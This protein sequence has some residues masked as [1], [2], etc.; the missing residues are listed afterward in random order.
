[1]KKAWIAAGLTLAVVGAG[2][3]GVVLNR[4][5]Q[6]AVTAVS[7]GG[8]ERTAAVRV[9][10]VAPQT[11]E[12]RAGQ[13]GVIETLLVERGNAVSVGD[14]LA[15]FSGDSLEAQLKEVEQELSALNVRAEEAAREQ[16]A[17]QA[18]QKEY[19]AVLS[20][21]VSAAE[22][23]QELA[24]SD[25][26]E[27]ETLNQAIEA[28]NAARA[29]A[30][31]AGEVAPYDDT[32]ERS[33]LNAQIEEL[34]ARLNDRT[35]YS[36]EAGKVVSVGFEEGQTVLEGEVLATVE[37]ESAGELRLTGTGLRLGQTLRATVNG[38]TWELSVNRMEGGVGYAKTPAGFPQ[39]GDIEGVVVQEEAKEVCLLPIECVAEDDGGEYAMIL[40]GGVL[41]RRAVT[42]GMDDGTTVAVTS[43][44]GVGEQAAYFPERYADGQRAESKQ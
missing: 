16:E 29:S 32:E 14:S 17:A 11:A 12:I 41:R 19:E 25:T 35:V 20:E 40:E 8:L 26:A 37:T 24:L 31:F 34:K 5:E 21:A 33:R 13:S 22:S 1:M 2:A 39:S 15:V 38:K 36:T 3:L 23:A 9:E 42:T 43:G 18:A 30:V 7:R 28:A 10:R 27:Y 4:P 44:V 6:I